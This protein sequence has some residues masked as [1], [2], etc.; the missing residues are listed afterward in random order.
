MPYND[1][2]FQLLQAL[3]DAE[4]E[5]IW[6]SALRCKPDDQEFQVVSH[7]MKVALVSAEWRAVHGHTLRNLGRRDHQL[8]WKRILIDVADKL[9]PGWKWTPYKM[10]DSAQEEDIER[11]ILEF[12]DARTKVAW[13]AMGEKDKAKFADQVNAEMAA[14]ASASTTQARRAGVAQVTTASLGAASAPA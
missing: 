14:A 7:E 4:L 12:F 10:D 3:D 9:N 8:P 1:R 6:V 11:K 13:E 5:S 2:L